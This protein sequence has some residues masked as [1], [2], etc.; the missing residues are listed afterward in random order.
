MPRKMEG[1]E[2]MTIDWLIRTM[3]T[4]RVVFDSAVHL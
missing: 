3:K 1:S 2:M 4:P